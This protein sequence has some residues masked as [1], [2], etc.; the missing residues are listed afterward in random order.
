MARLREEQKRQEEQARQEAEREA[1]R[2]KQER[3]RKLYEEMLEKGEKL[4]KKALDL[5][6]DSKYMWEYIGYLDGRMFAPMKKFTIGELTEPFLTYEEFAVEKEN[7]WTEQ[8][9]AEITITE[10]EQRAEKDIIPEH[11]EMS[12]ISDRESTDKQESIV[13]SEQDY[14]YEVPGQR[15]EKAEE[16]KKEPVVSDTQVQK[17]SENSRRIGQKKIVTKQDYE[18]MTGKEKAEWLGISESDMNGSISRFKEK[19]EQIGIRF[20]SRLDMTEAFLEVWGF[21][22]QT[23]QR[24]FHEHEPQRSR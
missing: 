8:Q 11:T 21:A 20:D 24:S 19:M 9:K 4:H 17:E 16:R 5:P 22:S 12:E 10:Q 23:Q 13:T 3:F 2:Q 7:E 18:R 15:N 6:Y 14:S 1:E